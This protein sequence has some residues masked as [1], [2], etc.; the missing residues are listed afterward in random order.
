MTRQK[1]G[2]DRVPIHYR[3]GID[4]RRLETRRNQTG[5]SDTDVRPRGEVSA[6]GL[7]RCY[8]RQRRRGGWGGDEGILG[9]AC[10]NSR[11]NF[12][13]A[14]VARISAT[15]RTRPF[16]DAFGRV[17]STRRVCDC[18]G[19]STQSAINVD[20]VAI[21]RRNRPHVPGA[22]LDARADEAGAAR[23]QGAVAAICGTQ[24]DRI[25]RTIARAR[26]RN[27]D[28]MARCWSRPQ[29]RAWRAYRLTP[30]WAKVWSGRSPGPLAPKLAMRAK[31]EK[32]FFRHAP[33]PDG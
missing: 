21:E 11:T 25:R 12:G 24:A 5:D 30:G 33:A 26:P 27:G 29:R 20:A 23:I 17:A 3:L 14:A 13:S 2:I 1:Y 10:G 32:V 8:A 9:Q 15:R 18:I 28:A 31:S 22:R 19:A 4:I 7:C 16:V 6:R